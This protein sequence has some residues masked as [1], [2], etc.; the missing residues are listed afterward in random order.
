MRDLNQWS[1]FPSASVIPQGSCDLKKEKKKRLKS[2]VAPP[3]PQ[4]GPSLTALQTKLTSAFCP[5]P[6]KGTSKGFF[7]LSP[8]G[9]L[10]V[11]NPNNLNSS[12]Q[13]SPKM[14]WNTI[15]AFCR[16]VSSRRDYH[17]SPT[18]YHITTP[19][20]LQCLSV[21]IYWAFNRLC[22][23]HSLSPLS[24][25]AALGKTKSREAKCIA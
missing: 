3:W 22:L 14:H 1:L 15:S 16:T 9:D 5:S 2:I 24:G 13:P 8:L 11:P 25:K 4:E 18:F 6:Q 7:E 17:L 21:N 20:K 12:L 10:L 19:P 23:L